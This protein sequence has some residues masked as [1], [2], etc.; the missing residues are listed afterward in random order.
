MVCERPPAAFGG[1][2][3]TE[4]ENGVISPSRGGDASEASEGVAH[5]S[6]GLGGEQHALTPGAT[7]CRR[8]AAQQGR[9]FRRDKCVRLAVCKEAH[10]RSGPLSSTFKLR[11]LLSRGF[12]SQRRFWRRHSLVRISMSWRRDQTLCVR[13]KAG[14]LHWNEASRGMRACV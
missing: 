8:S 14:P 7:I 9:G 13:T 1:S 10:N 3:L 5:T 11:F 6:S 4:G 2:P 12:P